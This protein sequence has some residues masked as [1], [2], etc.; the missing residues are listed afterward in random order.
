MLFNNV[1][2]EQLLNNSLLHYFK[3]IIC[4]LDSVLEY[5]CICRDKLSTKSTKIRCCNKGL[6]EFSF[7]ESQGI[8]IIPEI[9]NDLATF[10]LDLSIFSECLMSNKA[11]QC[12]KPFPSYFLKAINYKVKEDTFTT[13]E[14]KEIEDIKEN[15]KD[16]NRMRSFF[17]MLPAPDKLIKD[18]HNDSDLVE[19]FSKLPKVG[20]ESLAIYKLL[21]YLVCTNRVSFK[22]LS[23]DDKLSGVDDFDEYIIYNNESNEE[24]AFQ[25]M[26]RKK[27]SVW[28][29][30]GS[31]ME[32]WYSILRNGPRNLFHTE[33]MADEVDSEDIVYSSS[34]FAT[35]SGYT[36]PRN[37]EFRL[38]GTIPSWEHSKV[39]SKRIVGVLEII[40]N[41]SY[42]GNR[43]N[44]SLLADYSTFA[45]PDDHCIM[46]RYIWVF[47]QNDMY[48][49]RAARNN[50]TTNDIPFESQYY[51]TV[52]KIQEEQMNHRKE[53]LLEAHKRAKERYEEE[54][55]LKKKID[56][57][58][59]EQHENDK[60]KEKEQ[61]I[62]QRINTLESKMTGKGSAIAT[63][64]ILEEYKFF[65]TSSD[66]KN[67][68][69]KLP[70]DN[71]YKWVVSLD[72][73]KFE[74]TPE[75]KEDFECMKQQTGNGPEL[76]FEIVYTSSFPFDPPFIRVVKPIFKVHTGHVTVGG[77]LCIE[78]LTP[79]GWSSAR[80]IEGIFVEILSII[81]QG[82]TRIE[83]SS[84]GHTYSIQE[85]RAAFER[86]AKHHGWL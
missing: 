33:M 79:S 16:L 55:E 76:Q 29:F 43:N 75:L 7:E 85:A 21:Q 13:F 49:G 32:N 28:T 22:Q 38:D 14:K 5:C 34:D 1:T 24:E 25:E 73:L 12:L 71:F 44:N 56:L 47:S 30:H 58:V 67:F 53:R 70:N 23:D 35:A 41:P 51:S 52:R 59:K 6:C 9:K 2:T 8:Y 74:L 40:K 37:N 63:N 84:L 20:H 65:Q 82:E 39:K 26:K 69:I 72:I 57:Q 83:K 77:S 27:D 81:L 68:E 54:L 19:L 48:K 11:N 17:K 42:G 31:S 66:I 80:S 61:Q 62:D 78:S 50:L 60:A 4:S 18:R 64:R 10:S 15:N 36:R 46:L 45:C 3:H 86:V